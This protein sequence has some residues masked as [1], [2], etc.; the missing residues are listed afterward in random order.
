MIYL[1][2]DVKNAKSLRFFVTPMV[3]FF[4]ELYIISHK[5]KYIFNTESFG[6]YVS[7][8]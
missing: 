8:W 5:L 3:Y 1:K 6:V 2:T 7:K 4:C